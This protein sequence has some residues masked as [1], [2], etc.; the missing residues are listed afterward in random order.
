MSKSKFFHTSLFLVLS[1]LIAAVE[2]RALALQEGLTIGRLLV[3]KASP[4]DG[5]L[6]V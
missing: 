5:E 2:Q 4:L 3:K 1:S 6:I